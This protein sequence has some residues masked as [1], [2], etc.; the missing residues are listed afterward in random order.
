MK[1]TRATSLNYRPSQFRMTMIPALS[2]MIASAL[3]AMLPI[4]AKSPIL[5][6][7]GLM[8]FV[9]WRLLRR[10]VFPIWIGAPLGLFDDLVSGQPLGSA[11]FLWSMVMIAL[12]T[13][14]DRFIW[15]DYWMEWFFASVAISLCLIIGLLF[16]NLHGGP[17][18]I[19][20]I[21]PQIFFSILF[22]PLIAR[23]CSMLDNIR[24][25]R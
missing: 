10:D 15:R 22:Y 7:L 1:R 18:P 19:Q 8:M 13:I 12:E 16:A 3:P 2:V 14:E 24:L 11:I 4:I 25:G 20:M 5:P 9:S 21:L 23:I 6:P 17:T